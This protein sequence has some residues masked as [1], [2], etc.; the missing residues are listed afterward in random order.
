MPFFIRRSTIQ[1]VIRE[2]IEDFAEELGLNGYYSYTKQQWDLDGPIKAE[3]LNIETCDSLWKTQTEENTNTHK[4]LNAVQ[5]EL[6]QLMDHFG[7]QFQDKG[8]QVVP[9]T[10]LVASNPGENT[11][12]VLKDAL[13]AAGFEQV[14]I[15][16]DCG[17]PDCP[18]HGTKQDR[19]KAVKM[20]GGVS[21]R[22][23]IRRH[24]KTS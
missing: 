8:R 9:V 24:K 2:E 21:P 5:R 19:A 7:L 4:H 13:E 17:N 15:A 23:R 14:D 16:V 22:P 10:S 1:E 20:V 11:V 3:Y 6:R 12:A 18:V